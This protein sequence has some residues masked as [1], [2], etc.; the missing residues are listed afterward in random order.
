[1][2]QNQ[3]TQVSSQHNPNLIYNTF[4]SLAGRILYQSNGTSNNAATDGNNYSTLITTDGQQL[5]LNVAA[6]AAAAT[7]NGI[8]QVY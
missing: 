3:P 8:T 2:V 1:M 5:I 4:P 6:A 7:G